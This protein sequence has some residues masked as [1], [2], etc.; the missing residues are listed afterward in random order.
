M[1]V[2][3]LA[4]L[5]VIIF[6]DFQQWPSIPCPSIAWVL[7]RARRYEIWIPFEYV[8]EVP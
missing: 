6:S 8:I 5:A 4:K 7:K 1:L 2:D 3:E